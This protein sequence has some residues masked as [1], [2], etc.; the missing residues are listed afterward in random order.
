MPADVDAGP[1]VGWVAIGDRAVGV[2]FALGAL[3]AG[4]VS[5][6]SVSAGVVAVGGVS[7]G[8]VSLGGVSVGL[9]VLG[10]VA[11]GV[12]ALGGLSYGWTAALGAVAVARDFA[13]GGLAIGEHANDAAARAFAVE[14]HLGTTFYVL[15]AAVFVLAVLPNALLAWRT[16][17]RSGPSP[18]SG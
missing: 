4:G 2:L 15:L 16:R 9:L 14:H 3:A 17:R 13:F 1:A 11:V 8:L 10:S 18:Q 5:V 7:V 6:G 12:V